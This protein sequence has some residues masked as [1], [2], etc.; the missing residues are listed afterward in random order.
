M[1]S[2][3]NLHTVDRGYPRDHLLLMQLFPQP[4]HEKIPNRTQYYHELVTRI[5][6]VPGVE[7][8]SYLHMGPASS[9]ELK[10]PVSTGRGRA[11]VNAAEEWAGPG[12][13]HMIGMRVLAGR[14]FDWRDDEHAPRVAVIGESLARTLFANQNPIARSM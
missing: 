7:S 8:V 11:I 6:Q 9:Y 10:A 5:S 3:Q 13:F 2:L 1:R 14:E 12:F 4:E